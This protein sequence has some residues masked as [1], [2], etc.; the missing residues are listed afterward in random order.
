MSSSFQ[1]CELQCTQLPSSSLLPWVYPNSCPLSQRCHPTIS[2]S[3]GPFSSYLQSFPASESFPMRQL[4]ASGGQS[5]R[6]SALYI[7][8]S[9]TFTSSY[10]LY[11]RLDFRLSMV[12]V[13][14]S[15]HKIMMD[16][17]MNHVLDLMNMVYNILYIILMCYSE[18]VYIYTNICN[19]TYVHRDG[20]R[21]ILK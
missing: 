9:L 13:K 18:Y 21:A 8:V 16:F 20:N 6:T 12:E 1:L 11:A 3:V 5:T 17:T 4:F 14:R 19:Y 7:M 10:S 2:S 15:I